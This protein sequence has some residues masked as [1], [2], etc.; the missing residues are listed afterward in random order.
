M[1]TIKTNKLEGLSWM[2]YIFYAS[3]LS[4]LLWQSFLSCICAV[5]GWT[6]YSSPSSFGRPT[7]RKISGQY[8]FSGSRFQSPGKDSSSSKSWLQGPVIF[9]FGELQRATA[10]FSSVHQIGEGGFG[11][12]FK[13]KLDDGTIVAIKRA[14]KVV[15][16]NPFLG[17][18]V[19]KRLK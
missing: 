9:S 11:T 17:K 10:H 15:I 8:R 12:V 13:G 19:D 14:R 2:R 5:S 4:V 7:E 18:Y 3:L 1:P 6:G 16:K